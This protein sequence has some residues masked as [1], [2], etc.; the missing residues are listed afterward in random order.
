M[1]NHVVSSEVPSY[2]P[3]TET[4]FPA[5]SIPQTAPSKSE[6]A[7]AIKSIPSGIVAGIDRI[8]AE[9]C[10]SN[11]YMA[12]EVLQPILE[13]AW[14]NEA[15]REELTDGIIVKIPKTS[16]LKICDN[17]RRICVLPAISKII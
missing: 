9:F 17:W 4:I 1:L 10:N 2:A 13:E 12:A 16:N 5:K 8:P 15:F 11:A 3:T 14:L 7:F 6:I